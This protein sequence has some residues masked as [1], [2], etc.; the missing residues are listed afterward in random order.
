MGFRETGTPDLGLEQDITVNEA[1]ISAIGSPLIRLDAIGLF[2]VSNAQPQSME[3]K[4]ELE[5]MQQ[6]QEMDG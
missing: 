5:D 1:I 4:D 3:L 2:V 6:S